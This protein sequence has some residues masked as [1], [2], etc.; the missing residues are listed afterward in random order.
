MNA[1]IITELS[2]LNPPN[3]KFDNSAVLLALNLIGNPQNK[4]KTIHL[5]GTNGK[6]STAA[7]IERGLFLAGYKVGKFSSPYIHVI[8]ECI[9]ING[10]LIR[11]DDLA[12]L[13]VSYKDKLLQQQIHLSSF[14]MLTVLMFI[15]CAEN[16]IDYLVLE[17]GM[18]GMDD[19][20]NVVD[21]IISIIT[22][23][24]LEHTQFLGD[25]LEKIAQHKAG[26]IKN[27]Y[28]IV[29]DNIAQIINA[30]DARSTNYVSIKDKYI[31]EKISLNHHDFTTDIEFINH[32]NNER[33]YFTLNLFGHFQACNFLCAYEAL[34]FLK[35][36]HRH[37]ADAA[38]SVKWSGRLQKISDSPLIIADASHNADGVVSLAKSL[39][40]WFPY[41]N[42]VIIC[43]IL[44]DK[45]IDEMLKSY[46]K[47]SDTI[48]FCT[49]PEQP[50]ASLSSALAA[51][52]AKYF[53]AIYA[54]ETPEQAVEIAQS[55][56][57]QA[58]LITGSCYLLKYFI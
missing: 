48:I 43:S 22:N 7:F 21:S 17:A 29:G 38:K 36:S 28:T 42:S 13:Y 57:K 47:I 20:T 49:L 26:I 30:V 8:N 19:A 2:N 53:N 58:T 40:E 16:N 14:E 5:A 51:Y 32:T 31:V 56:H 18:G 52:S 10:E 50:R 37:I 6:G 24:S 4:Y 25:N 35:I 23:I 44:N 27:G 12:N 33:H 41:H 46:S 9:S 39:I 3:Q 1:T 55:L 45:N 15:Y 11:D 34:S 54:T